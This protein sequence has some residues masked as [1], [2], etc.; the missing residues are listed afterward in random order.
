ML[1]T[2]GFSPATTVE[3]IAAANSPEFGRDPDLRRQ[4]KRASESPCP[5]IA[6]GFSRYHPRD[7]ARFVNIAKSSMSE[8]IVHMTRA[9]RKQLV[10]ADEAA[11]VCALARRARAAA[12]GYIRYLQRA[13]LAPATK[14]LRRRRKA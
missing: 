10:T 3:F 14:G 2:V 4:I 8:L 11:R 5:N 13:E 7:N 1:P 12:M 9:S 6:E